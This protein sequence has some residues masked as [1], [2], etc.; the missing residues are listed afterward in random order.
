MEWITEG[1]ALI[2]TGILVALV[3]IIGDNENI[4]SR[5]VCITSSAFLF[6]MA[7]LSF[8]TGY[9]VNF[10]PYKLCPYIFSGSGILILTGSLL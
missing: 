1:F 8:F 3:A 2:F 5:I 6:S 9:K 7:I 4:T 10:L